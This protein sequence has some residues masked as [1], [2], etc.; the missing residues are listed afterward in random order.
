MP[1]TARFRCKLTKYFYIKKHLT[2]NGGVEK[3]LPL[4]LNLIYYINEK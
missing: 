4:F 3:Y 1:L 2:N